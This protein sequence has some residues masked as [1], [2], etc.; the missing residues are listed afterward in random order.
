MIER[1]G[2]AGRQH[3]HRGDTAQAEKEARQAVDIQ[4]KTLPKGH[5]N[6]APAHL[7]L[8]RALT[9]NGK[10]M[11]MKPGRS[12]LRRKKSS[13]LNSDYRHAVTSDGKATVRL[14]KAIGGSAIY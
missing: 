1:G 10:L 8:G 6:L 13:S 12:H 9:K 5:R 7:A 14:V 2:G 3:L 11:R 4:E